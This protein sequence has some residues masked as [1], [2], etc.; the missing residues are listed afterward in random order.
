MVHGMLDPMPA[1]PTAI[2][3]GR[4]G[5]L[6]PP[7]IGHLKRDRLDA[8]I[9]GHIALHPGLSAHSIGRA[10]AVG[11]TYTRPGGRVEVYNKPVQQSLGRLEAAGLIVADTGPWPGF[12]G[13]RRT[14]RLAGG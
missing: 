10:P 13:T 5:L 4:V 12:G 6:M 3:A 14:W 9:L 11:L 7:P 1:M 2:P 8:K